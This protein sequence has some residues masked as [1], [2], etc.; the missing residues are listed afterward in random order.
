MIIV[1][2]VK[3]VQVSRDRKAHSASPG[4]LIREEL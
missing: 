2:K 3:T 1:A 4:R